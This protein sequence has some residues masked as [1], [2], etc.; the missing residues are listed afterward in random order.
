[1]SGE[2]FDIRL[3]RHCRYS[4]TDPQPAPEEIGKYYESTEYVSHSDTTRGI[5]NKLY[6]IVRK[7]NTNNKL[8][9]VNRL[10][11]VPSGLLDVGCGTGY[12]LSACRQNGRQAEGVEI[13]DGARAIAAARTGQPV[14]PSMDA[15]EATGRRFDVITLWQVF[16]HLHQPDDSFARLKRLLKPSGKLIMA[17]PNRASADA[18]HYGAYWAAYDVPRHLSHFSPRSIRRLATKHQMKI[19]EIVPMKFDAYY[20]SMLSEGL[21][22]RGKFRALLNGFRQGYRSNRRARKDGH[23]SSL[24]YVFGMKN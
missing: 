20:V 7:K 24:I 15:L 9:L 16:E 11:P 12:F 19:E 23:Y 6:H 21:K 18:V 5:I 17:L 10:S 1:V 8:K 22:G 2:I 13:N 4:F 14:Y 3:C